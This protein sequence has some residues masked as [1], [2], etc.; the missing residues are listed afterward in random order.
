VEKDSHQGKNP[1][2]AMPGRREDIPA[3]AQLS[4]F[5]RN[6]G[7]KALKARGRRR[8]TNSLSCLLEVLCQQLGKKKMVTSPSVKA[9]EETFLS[10]KKKEWPGESRSGGEGRT[11][12]SSSLRV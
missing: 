9:E 5:L 1:G 2:S 4:P 8:G 12:S 7:R 3:H 11:S 6:G 10:R